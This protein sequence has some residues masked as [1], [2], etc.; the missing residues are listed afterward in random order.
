MPTSATNC[1]FL[2]ATP[3]DHNY[4]LAMF[5]AH[6]HNSLDNGQWHIQGGAQG[7]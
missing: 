5:S 7:A 3:I 6:V 1:T 2:L 4:C